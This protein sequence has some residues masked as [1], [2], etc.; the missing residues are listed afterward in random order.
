MKINIEG[1]RLLEEILEDNCI[2]Y[3]KLILFVKSEGTKGLIEHE[4]SFNRY[5]NKSMI[6]EELIKLKK[7]NGYKDKYDFYIL[8]ENIPMLKKEILYIKENEHKIINEA[9][10][11]VYK[12]IPKDIKVQPNIYIYAGGIDGGFTVYRKNIFI[13]YIKYINK[14]QEFVKII[15]HELFHC[16]TI[17]LTN[18]LKSLFVL[19]FNNRYVY[20]ILGKILEEGIAC[21]IQHGNILEE[22]DPVG[23]LTKEKIKK[24]DKKIRDLNCFLLGIKQG[25]INYS[26]TEVLDI[27]TIGYYIASSLY[28]FYGRGA[29]LPWIDSYNYKKPIKSY[30]EVAKT[31]KTNSGFTREIEKWLLKL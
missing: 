14:P 25:N 27:Y 15:S 20:E 23:T 1:I 21:L 5:I 31:V 18:R 6:V 2:D 28:D 8:K 3:N 13:N 12:F 19:S 29:L 30:I 16:R 22:D 11:K 10:D 4:R 17:P 24:I 9:L 7:Y 26:R